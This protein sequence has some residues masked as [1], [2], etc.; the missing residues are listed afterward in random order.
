MFWYI[1]YKCLIRNTPDRKR[2]AS[3]HEY[4]VVLRLAATRADT[5]RLGL[6]RKP[7]DLPTLIRDFSPF[8][9]GE[10]NVPGSQEPGTLRR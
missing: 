8:V 7:R 1:R 10:L 2:S 3:G 5:S 4:I 9:W 6:I